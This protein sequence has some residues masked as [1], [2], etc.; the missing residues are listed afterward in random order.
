MEIISTRSR[1]RSLGVLFL[2]SGIAV[3]AIALAFSLPNVR[4]AFSQG[5][6]AIVL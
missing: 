1:P 3:L 4:L 6:V 2:K 5:A